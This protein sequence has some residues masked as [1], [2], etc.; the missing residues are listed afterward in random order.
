MTFTPLEKEFKLNILYVDQDEEDAKRFAGQVRKRSALQVYSP[1]VYHCKT[2]SKA[3]HWLKS[4]PDK[5]MEG[6]ML[7]CWDTNFP[8]ATEHMIDLGISELVALGVDPECIVAMPSANQTDLLWSVVKNKLGDDHVVEKQ[9]LIH[10]GIDKSLVNAAHNAFSKR[11][12]SNYQSMM[13]LQ[14]SIF[15]GELKVLEQRIDN[16]RDLLK[17]ELSNKVIE[18]IDDALRR[19]D[20]LEH[21][22]FPARDLTGAPSIVTLVQSHQQLVAS[23][24]RDIELMDRQIERLN[25]DI[26]EL[27]SLTKSRHYGIEQELGDQIKVVESKVVDLTN[28]LDNLKQSFNAK[29]EVMLQRESYVLQYTGKLFLFAGGAVIFLGVGAVAPE[30]IDKLLQLGGH[31]FK[32]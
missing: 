13:M 10:R 20:V 32:P 17:R 31:I 21:S 27:A 26:G 22:I 2:V 11:S 28:A 15:K 4:H 7:V 3:A 25:N 16:M 19:I 12:F 1:Q 29:K 8:G 6:T 9:D 30:L 14:S 24:S 18:K 23:N 5:L